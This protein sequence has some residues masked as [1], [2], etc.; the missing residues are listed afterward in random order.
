MSIWLRLLLLY[1]QDKRLISYK[2]KNT[3]C[4]KQ[5]FIQYNM[6]EKNQT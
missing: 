6:L 1:E 4:N 3:Q 5:S 2:Q